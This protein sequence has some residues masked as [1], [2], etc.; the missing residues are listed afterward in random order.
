MSTSTLLREGELAPNFSY[1]DSLGNPHETQDLRGGPFLVYFYPK[2]DTPG[3][4][5]EAC[6]FRDNYQAFQEQGIA[7]I[8]V[9]P[10]DEKSH[11][12]F[13]EKF[14]LPFPLACDSDH[15]IAQA[16]GAWGPKKFMGREYDG[17][18][19]VSFLVSAQGQIV[20]VYPKV[21]PE[22]HAQEILSD[23]IVLS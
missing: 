8:G 6:G 4:T 20:R 23:S 3:C 12:K 18:H 2:D 14:S 7:I 1:L 10:D 5:K 9:S 13:R 15:R 19:R 22:L 11:Q 21:K 17:V 16:Y